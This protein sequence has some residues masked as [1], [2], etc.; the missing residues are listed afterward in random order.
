[1]YDGDWQFN[2]ME[3]LGKLY[4]QSGQLA[5]EGMWMNDQFMG[6]GVLYN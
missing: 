5:Y 2:K 3:G 4:Y 1:M 6:K